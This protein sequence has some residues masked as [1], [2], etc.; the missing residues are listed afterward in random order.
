MDGPDNKK[1]EQNNFTTGQCISIKAQKA[2]R[3][4]HLQVS[5]H[6][7]IPDTCSFHQLLDLIRKIHSYVFSPVID[8]ILTRRIV[9]TILQ[10]LSDTVHQFD[11]MLT[12]VTHKHQSGLIHLFSVKN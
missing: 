3:T 1:T 5:I 8:Q 12:K 10:M 4:K 6:V 11:G 9:S 7:Q 2:F